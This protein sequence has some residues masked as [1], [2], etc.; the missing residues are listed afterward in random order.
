VSASTKSGEVLAVLTAVDAVL[1]ENLARLRREYDKQHA[2]TGRVHPALSNQCDRAEYVRDHFRASINA[3]HEVVADRDA[4]LSAQTMGAELN[5]PDFLEW[6]ADRLV[7][8]HGEHPRVDC[9]I[10]LRMRAKAG[11]EAIAR[12]KGGAS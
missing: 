3:F 11:R 9:V 6:I 8:V 7:H 4:L 1:S 5:T 12:C 2:K 10:S